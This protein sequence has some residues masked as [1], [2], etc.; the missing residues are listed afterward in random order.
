MQEALKP[1][2]RYCLCGG[3]ADEGIAITDMLNDMEL[4]AEPWEQAALTLTR[5]QAAFIPII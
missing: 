1:A 5:R 4:P 3:I 2:R